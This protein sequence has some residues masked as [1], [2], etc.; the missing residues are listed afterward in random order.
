MKGFDREKII[1]GVKLIIEGIGENPDDEMVILKDIPIYSMCEHHL[2]PFFGTVSVA[3][4]PKKGKI[5]ELST[6]ANLVDTIA[7]K[8][9]LQ[10][11][12]TKQIA[13]NITFIYFLFK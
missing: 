6:I 8:L 12:L 5:M 10:E 9:Q 3:Y 7:K 4:I 2:L 13:D 11:R 1:R